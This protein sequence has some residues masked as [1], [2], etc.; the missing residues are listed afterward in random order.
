MNGLEDLEQEVALATTTRVRIPI[1]RRKEELVADLD[2][3]DTT[4]AP[5][6]TVGTA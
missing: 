1:V 4:R 5:A 2:R 3:V 6:T